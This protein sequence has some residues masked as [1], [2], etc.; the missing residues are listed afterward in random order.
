MSRIIIKTRIE[1]AWDEITDSVSTM[2]IIFG[3][4]SFFVWLNCMVVV[5]TCTFFSFISNGF[6]GAFTLL[7]GLLTELWLNYKALIVSALIL[8]L[9]FIAKVISLE[10]E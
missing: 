7:S 8:A 1:S 2:M 9:V 6:E 5:F 3:G 10:K 4:M